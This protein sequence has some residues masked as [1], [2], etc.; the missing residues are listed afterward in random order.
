METSPSTDPQWTRK[1]TTLAVLGVIVV[2]AVP[3]PF[4][5]GHSQAASEY[6]ALLQGLAST[7]AL[8][9]L[10]WTLHLQRTELHRQQEEMRAST[11]EQREQKVAMQAQLTAMNEQARSTALML[12]A[13]IR[14]ALSMRIKIEP[15][16]YHLLARNVGVGVAHVRSVLLTDLATEKS[17]PLLQLM[18]MKAREVSISLSPETHV[19]GPSSWI[20]PDVE[21]ELAR[22][23]RYFEH[24]PGVSAGQRQFD[25]WLQTCQLEVQYQDI[26]RVDTHWVRESFA[27]LYDWS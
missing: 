3:L 5:L 11:T 18:G 23:P 6:G 7:V 8:I 26:L 15:T 10:L 21:I 24:L 22:I 13:S 27:G 20:R 2:F 9:L 16:F 17:G 12:Q 25:V 4:T 14:P 19:R 1:H